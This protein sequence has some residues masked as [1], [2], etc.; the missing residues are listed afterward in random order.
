MHE[1]YVE[2]LAQ[3]ALS[4]CSADDGKG[5]GSGGSTITNSAGGMES[6]APRGHGFRYSDYV[7]VNAELVVMKRSGVSRLKVPCWW[8]PTRGSA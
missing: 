6:F 8:S 3:T 2:R 7:G 1:A 4:K 5:L